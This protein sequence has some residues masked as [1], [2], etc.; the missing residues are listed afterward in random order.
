MIL[1]YDHH[2]L[3]V[4]GVVPKFMRPTCW[5]CRT[6]APGPGLLV[7]YWAWAWGP[8]SYTQNIYIYTQGLL[9]AHKTWQ[10]YACS[11]PP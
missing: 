8:Q 3:L 2:Q 6:M 4:V 1:A 11:S 10:R 5:P 7:N 9:N